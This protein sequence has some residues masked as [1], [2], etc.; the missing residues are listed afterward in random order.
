MV[1]LA[2]T[3]WGG[4]M[5]SPDGRSWGKKENRKGLET[6]ILMQRGEIGRSGKEACKQQKRFLRWDTPENIVKIQVL[7]AI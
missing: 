5:R 4:D 3:G 1:F 2:V 7:P 6:S